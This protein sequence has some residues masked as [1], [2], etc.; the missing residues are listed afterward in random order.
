M[1]RLHPASLSPD[2]LYGRD[3]AA[4]LIAEGA[5]AGLQ[6]FRMG[7][8]RVADGLAPERLASAEDLDPFAAQS[9]IRLTPH[10]S[11]GVGVVI[12]FGTE[13][14][15]E[16]ELT[17]EAASP[18]ALFVSWGESLPEACGWGLP[19]SPS[20]GFPP[21]KESWPLA[22]GSAKRVFAA[23][24][25]RYVRVDAFDGAVAV[26]VCAIVRLAGGARVG[27]FRCGDPLFQRL[28]Q[29][30]LYTARACTRPRAFWDGIKRDRHGWYGD[31]RITQAS[32][33]AGFAAPGSAEGMLLEWPEHKW[34]NGIPAFSFDACAMLRQLLVAHGSARPAIPEIYRRMRAFL[35]WVLGTQVDSRLRLVH[36]EGVEYFF[37]IGFIDWSPQ[38][39]GGR[40]EELP[41]LQCAWC[42]A[43]GH[44]A[45]VACWLGHDE[46]ASAWSAARETLAPLIARE[47]WRPGGFPHTL[48]RATAE[49]IWAMPH[50]PGLHHRLSYL[51]SQRFGPS[52]PSRHAA[53]RAALAG[54]LDASMRAASLA[55]FDDPTV[56][57]II[58]PFYQ[59]YEQWGRAACGDPLG[60]LSRM[61]AYLE[62]MLV[63]NDGATVWESFEPDVTGF[64]RWGLHGFP[65][66]LCHGW[67]SGLVPLTTRWLLGVEPLA[68]GFAEVA[69][70]PPAPVAW[71]YQATVPTPF[72]PLRIARDALGSPVQ[73][74]VPDGIVVR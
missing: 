67:G 12:D 38:P 8:W 53:A 47:L 15:A 34:A 57:G 61:G 69:L 7:P 6:V 62:A 21:A 25:F 14:D 28:W 56:P 10:P 51:E 72:G 27:D 31:A 49:E 9:P 39:L 43:L 52:R 66:S 3:D 73:Y 58:T 46:D 74:S 1:P 54:V 60:A 22:V 44:A 59:F 18:A 33:D 41:W 65:K 23:R 68:P 5:D 20:N 13:L 30:S 45:Q 29:T 64:A 63:P 4:P 2:P 70:H 35:G 17:V 16:L 24:G 11:R 42:E 36:R 19:P 26:R 71:A 48:E 55:V 50:S 40:F 37:G 32:L